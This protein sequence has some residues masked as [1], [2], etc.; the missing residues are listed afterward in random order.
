MFARHALPE[1]C[2]QLAA[3]LGQ[4]R[5][6]VVVECEAVVQLDLAAAAGGPEAGAGA[7][8]AVELALLAPR[9]ATEVDLSIHYSLQSEQASMPLSLPAVAMKSQGLPHILPRPTSCWM[10]RST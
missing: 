4:L 6:P 9:A 10:S 7:Q 8:I 5:P 1:P 3:A 2:L